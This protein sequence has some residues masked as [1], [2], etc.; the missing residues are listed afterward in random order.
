MS[1]AREVI[2][3]NLERALREGQLED[4]AQLLE[5]LRREAPLE[6]PTR[7]LE[8]EYLLAAGRL[9]EARALAEQLVKLFPASARVF[10]LA[11]RTAYARRRYDRALELFEE[12]GRLK[13]H[14]RI[15]Y[16]I[17]KTLTQAG[18]LDEA[19]PIL[20]DVVREHPFTAPALAWLHERRGEVDEAIRVL[21][22]HCAAR[23]GDR[24]AAEQLER[25]RARRLDPERLEEEVES[26]LEL[27]EAVPPELLAEHV[28]GLLKT[29]Q[30]P[31]VREL[32]RS[33]R[34]SLD[35]RTALRI[36][37]ICHRNGLPDLAYSLFR[38]QLSTHLRDVKLL[39]AMEK[40]ARLAGRTEE[41]V[42]IYRELAVQEPRLWGRLRR[43]SRARS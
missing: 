43:L 12:A 36:A 14:W 34:A 17:G 18:R 29:G 20:V 40:D 1:R 27:G 39:A 25:L 7:G 33:C 32:L 9:D 22:R 24:F 41:L 26:L 13:P 4:A 37:W 21:E 35:P 31:R 11:G 10:F 23:P 19:E 28:E 6:L 30:G 15:R 42:E 5:R 3:R 38:E 16:W 2:R 8:L